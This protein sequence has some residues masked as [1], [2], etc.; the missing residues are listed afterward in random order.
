MHRC[1][2]PPHCVPDSAAGDVLAEA[3]RLADLADRALRPI[4]D[5]CR[6]NTGAMAAIALVDMLDDLLAPLMFEIDV[7]IGRFAP[8]F[9]D[10]AREEQVMLR[11]G[12]TQVIPEHV[13]DG[14]IGRGAAPLAQDA[15][16][17]GIAHD[18]VDGQE[19]ARVIELLGLDRELLMEDKLLHLCRAH[20]RG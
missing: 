9:R 17:F 14:G 16:V 6:G 1:P 20:R 11:I 8:L 15:L 12:S 2:R 10:E 13:A 5:H 7:D 18:V 4:V 19:I 3:E